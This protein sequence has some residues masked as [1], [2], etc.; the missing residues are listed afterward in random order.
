MEGVCECVWWGVHIPDSK[1]GNAP[2]PPLNE[3]SGGKKVRKMPVE[4]GRWHPTGM[5]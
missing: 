2:S 5:Y 3:T 1:G 4:R